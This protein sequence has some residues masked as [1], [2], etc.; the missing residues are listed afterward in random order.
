MLEQKRLGL[1]VCPISIYIYFV[2]QRTF[3][4]N[5]FF[6]TKESKG[7]GEINQK[8]LFQKQLLLIKISLAVVQYIKLI[9]SLI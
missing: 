9:I 6:T 5:I 3:E 7:S 8:V 2:C 1:Y 4:F